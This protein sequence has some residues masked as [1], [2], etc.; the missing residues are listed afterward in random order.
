[1]CGIAGIAT[2]LASA[3]PQEQRVR[4]MTAALTHRGPDDEGHWCD[5]ET[6]IALGQRRLSIIDLSPQGHQPMHSASGRYVLSYNGEVYNFL[7]LRAQLDGQGSAPAWRGHSDTEVLLACI[8]AWGIAGTLARA[9]GMF[10]ISLW[11]RQTRT[12]TL[13]R[14]RLGEKPLY[15]G[16][17][18]GRLLFGSELKALLPAAEGR[19]RVSRPA[20]AEYMRYGYVP[21]PWSIYEGV[22][23]LPAGHWL[24]LRSVADATSAPVPY[25]GVG[26]AAVTDAG[27]SLKEKYA[28]AD[29]TILTDAVE[30]RLAAAVQGQLASDVPLGAFLSGGVDSSVV[31][32]MMQKHGASRARTFTIGF[33]QA[34]FDEAPFAAAVARHLN[35][36][37]TELYV[38]ASDAEQLIPRLPDIYDEPFAD[39]SQIPTTLVAQLT[40][41]HVTVALSGD[42]GDEL[43]AGYPRYALAARLWQRSNRLPAAFRRLLAS[44]LAAPSPS[45]W[46]AVL[47]RL[48][49]AARHHNVNGRRL[50]RMAQLL[51]TSSQGEMY[52]RLMSQWQ[53]EE[54][55]VRGVA[56][57]SFTLPHWDATRPAQEAMRLWDARQYLP[58]DLLVKVD[59]ATMSTSLEARAPMLDHRLVELAF[60][61]P[62]RA[63]VR[64][65]VGKWVLRQVLYRHVPRELIERPKAG[66]A[67]PLGAWLR[68][69]LRAWAEELLSPQALASHDLFEPKPI[70]QMWREHLT[71][72]VDRSS[73]LW[74]VL[75]FQAWWRRSGFVT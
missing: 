50:H 70:H 62:E 4:Q 47:S 22:H 12:L 75:M 36:E 35:T 3:H 16:C 60:A 59:R 38:N 34:G 9:V 74:T 65:D 73:Y 39:S 17:V 40:R 33:D 43:F 56:D 54:G 10:A 32:A 46:D 58:D 13:A 5:N 66:F 52:L 30:Q 31:V 49:P 37:H 57:R 15:Y 6:G 41:K 51:T 2:W 24:Q 53:P 45:A 44:T 23:K 72:G 48:L 67:V 20:L 68:G 26:D 14:D 21:A 18:G 55:L 8:E 27:T 71:G 61:L 19:L 64:G 11:D 29:D 63:L 42:G 7:A 69:P 28:Q 25:W 1:M